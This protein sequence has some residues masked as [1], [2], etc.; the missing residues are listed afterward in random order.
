M[1]TVSTDLTPAVAGGPL[2]ELL[3]TYT[4]CLDLSREYVRSTVDRAPTTD[5]DDDD[6]LDLDSLEHFLIARANLFAVAEGNLD[7][8][9]STDEPERRAVT[10]R[11]RAILEEMTEIE[12]QLSAFLGDRLVKMRD[13]ISQMQR[14][15]PVFTRYAHLG[16]HIHPSRITRHE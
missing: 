5:D 12:N 2:A 1:S 10:S 16:G 7:T 13:T 6:G 3:E 14:A 9:I 4:R 15:R 8:L 11:V